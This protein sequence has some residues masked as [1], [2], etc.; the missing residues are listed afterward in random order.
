MSSVSP[1]HD[2]K[3]VYVRG[4]SEI[5]F[6]AFGLNKEIYIV[7]LSIQSKCGKIRTRKTPITDSFH[8]VPAAFFTTNCI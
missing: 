3:V 7:N 4:F 6:P 1:S 2:V 5:Y 8:A